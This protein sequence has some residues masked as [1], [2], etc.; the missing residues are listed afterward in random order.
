MSTKSSNGLDPKTMNL[1]K[2]AVTGS[3]DSILQALTSGA[4]IEERN[5]RGLTPLMVAAA[6]GR[7]ETVRALVEGGADLEARV[8]RNGVRDGVSTKG[9]TAL[10]LASRHTVQALL[11]AGANIEART[12]L[13]HTPLMMAKDCHVVQALIAAGA[14]VNART[15][16]GITALE[17]MGFNGQGLVEWHGDPKWQRRRWRFSHSAE[18]REL[19]LAAGAELAK[20]TMEFL[21]PDYVRSAIAAGADPNARDADGMSALYIAAQAGQLPATQTLLAYGASCDTLPEHDLEKGWTYPGWTRVDRTGRHVL[22]AGDWERPEWIDTLESL[23]DAGVDSRAI[24]DSIDMGQR[25]G[26]GRTPLMLAARYLGSDNVQAL[27]AAGADLNAQDIFGHTAVDHA[28]L[29]RRPRQVVTL[30]SA[31]AEP[32]DRPASD[33]PHCDLALVGAGF[34]PRTNTITDPPDARFLSSPTGQEASFVQLA[35][36]YHYFLDDSNDDRPITAFGAEPYT[37]SETTQS[38]LPEEYAAGWYYVLEDQGWHQTQGAGI[39]LDLGL[40]DWAAEPNRGGGVLRDHYGCS[41]EEAELLR[42]WVD[43]DAVL[44]QWTTQYEEENGDEPTTLVI[45]GVVTAYGSPSELLEIFM[46][47]RHEQELDALT[48]DFAE[49]FLLDELNLNRE[50][51]LELTNLRLAREG[52]RGMIPADDVSIEHLSAVL[53][54]ARYTTTVGEDSKLRVGQ[55]PFARFSVTLSTRKHRVTFTT[56]SQVRQGIRREEA[57]MAANAYNEQYAAGR[58][59]FVKRGARNRRILFKSDFTYF[60]GLV[61]LNMIAHFQTFEKQV[62]ELI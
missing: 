22:D 25:D 31:G 59:Y 9:A 43:R 1:H 7:P 44:E 61:P 6:R 11:D 34:M 55:A 14:D 10:M 33:R 5:G 8:N 20:G 32:C 38:E 4:D 60:G 3:A 58:A 42:D 56:F 40:T 48:D 30:L 46:P 16:D 53:N 15:W 29:T 2:L 26:Y 28:R 19:L 12:L 39:E 54:A 35:F 18:R 23:I 36:L 51:L 37:A 13:G 27:V 21:T 41:D 45:P 17:L 24:K 62:K 47:V 57:S 49:N 50:V 52:V